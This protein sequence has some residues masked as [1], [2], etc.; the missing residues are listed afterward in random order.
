MLDST[1]TYH[2][3]AKGAEAIATRHAGLTPR[4]RALLIL[5]D[6][7]RSV[8]ELS[9][10]AAALGDP[11]ELLG[12]LA[13]Q[14]YIESGDPRA[15]P[16]TGP[17]ALPSGFD[18]LDGILAPTP[19]PAPVGPNGLQVPLTEAKRFAVAQL[20]DLLGPV[21]DDLCMRIRSAVS[22]HE[23]RAAVRRTETV[24]RD[25]VGPELASQFTRD[26]ENL[27]PR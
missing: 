20:S 17:A 22:A 8:Q 25:M 16:P 7:R 24:L 19:M 2:K 14:G 15:G 23:F 26:V 5:V 3:S 18:L 13:E 10:I 9:R 11:Q 6:G 12:Q 4:Q 21:G 27:K 1:A